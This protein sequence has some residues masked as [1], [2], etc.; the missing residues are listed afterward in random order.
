MSRV[1]GSHHIFVRPNMRLLVNLRNVNG[2]AK[3][4]QVRHFFQIIERYN[5]QLEDEHE[6]LPHQSGYLSNSGLRLGGLNAVRTTGCNSA[7]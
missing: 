6:S 1:S 7:N 3:P 2:K 5:L 4:Y